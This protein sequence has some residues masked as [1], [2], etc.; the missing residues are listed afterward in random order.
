MVFAPFTELNHHR[1]LICF[2]VGLLRDEKVDSFQWLFNS[3]LIAMGSHT[4]KTVITD[5]HSGITQAIADVFET[6]IHRFYM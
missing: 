3:F 4:P 6:S 2:S 1:Q 5:Q